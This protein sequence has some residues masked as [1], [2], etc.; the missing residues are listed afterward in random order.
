M[1]EEDNKEGVASEETTTDEKKPTH[2]DLWFEKL[3]K[4]DPGLVV[5][6][7]RCGADH[8]LIVKRWQRWVYSY[9]YATREKAWDTGAT[10]YHLNAHM[11][12]ESQ[13]E[14]QM[15]CNWES[16]HFMCTSCGYS[17]PT[18][19]EF[20]VDK[21]DSEYDGLKV[22]VALTRLLPDGWREALQAAGLIPKDDPTVSLLKAVESHMHELDPD[23]EGLD[24][25]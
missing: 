20:I 11:D 17:S 7:P 22:P 3:N 4:N 12:V 19:G 23:F 24:L 13:I 16:M 10:E 15:H 8:R 1:S 2:I 5:E 6:C 21:S 18:D 25:I 14:D 9:V